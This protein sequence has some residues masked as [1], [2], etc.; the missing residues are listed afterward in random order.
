MATGV[1]NKFRVPF[2]RCPYALDQFNCLVEWEHLRFGVVRNF[3]QPFV[4]EFN[5]PAIKKRPI[6]IGRHEHGPTAVIRYSDDSGSRHDVSSS[7][8][9]WR[10]SSPLV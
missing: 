8:G 6:A 9:A 10:H 1:K 4:H 7:A 3:G 5:A 2:F